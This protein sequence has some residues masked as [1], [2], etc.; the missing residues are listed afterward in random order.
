MQEAMNAKQQET[1]LFDL[2]G[3]NA[4]VLGG[5]S[6]L[7]KAMAAALAGAG[8]ELMIADINFNMAEEVA[9]QLIN[10][11][12][13]NHAPFEVDVTKEN[14]V[15]SMVAKAVE[16]YGKIDIVVESAG[17][18]I[19]G[20]PMIDFEEEMWDRIIDINLKGMFFV[21]KAV[22]KQM[23]KQKSGR[24]INV[25]SMSSVVI[26][27]NPYGS[28]GVYC[29]SKAGVINLTKAFAA[30]LAPYG[31]TVNAIS[32]GYMRTPLSASFW[33]NPDDSAEKCSKIPMGRPGEPEEL[34]GLVV[35]LASDS[36]SY[37]TGANLIIDGGYTV[38]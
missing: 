34:S 33:E 6:G 32:P 3:K 19:T 13:Q 9:G 35:Y 1:A 14:S 18:T 27:N 5:A 12:S 16:T 10:S 2:T 4:I 30:D 20:T 21:N 23:I 29:T 36:S 7:G 11:H 17:V 25:G 26:N 15:K 37:M 28:S 22:G 38:W 31:I 24:I 8:A